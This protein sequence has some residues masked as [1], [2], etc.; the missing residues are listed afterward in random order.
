MRSFHCLKGV[1]FSAIVVILSTA[2]MSAQKLSI[3][4]E[5]SHVMAIGGETTGW[6]VHLDAEI[7][8]DGKTMRSIEVRD[9]EPGRLEGFVGKRITATGRIAHRQGIE[10]GEKPFLRIASVNEAL[11]STLR[12]E[13]ATGDLKGSEWVLE[14]LSGLG[15]IDRVQATLIFPEPGKVAGKASCNRFFGTVH[16]QGD[17]IKFGPLGS[18]RMAC[19]EAVMKQEKRYLDALQ[20]AERVEWK[21]LSL[22]I[23][24]N[25]SKKP[26][27]FTRATPPGANLP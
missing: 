20:A 18:T 16:I 11:A 17:Q 14:D 15:V 3:T 23:Y 8:V 27:R 1:V 4:G 6:A 24:T 21:Y 13:N 9:A 12:T 2:I 10:T 26:L 22:L 5:L 25:G 7:S 19:P